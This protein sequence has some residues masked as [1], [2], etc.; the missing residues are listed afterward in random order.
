MTPKLA[1]PR[2]ISLLVIKEGS[3]RA[4][5]NIQILDPL[6]HIA[7]LT[8]YTLT[9]CFSSNKV[10]TM[11]GSLPTG[12]KQENMQMLDR[13]RWM[14]AT[15]VPAPECRQKY[16]VSTERA[17]PTL[18]TFSEHGKECKGVKCRLY[19]KKPK[20]EIPVGDIL[21]VGFMTT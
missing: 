11:P 5:N 4:R 14:P 10:P 19:K 16:A 2:D 15:P 12:S 20:T 13:I 3:S 8:N 6:D 17:F 9:T 18:S 21:Q 7:C 1:T